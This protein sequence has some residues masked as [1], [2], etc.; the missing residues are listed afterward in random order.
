MLERIFEG[1]I[2]S[3]ANYLVVCLF[4]YLNYQIKTMQADRKAKAEIEEKARKRQ[5]AVLFWLLKETLEKKIKSSINAGSIAV[6]DL[7]SLEDGFTLYK[8]MG[9]NGEVK[10]NM[11]IVRELP[12]KKKEV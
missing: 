8:E 11:E 5:E 2:S 3:S 12:H 7:A 6:K 9:G 10:I 1:I 4:A